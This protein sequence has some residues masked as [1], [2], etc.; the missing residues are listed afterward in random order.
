MTEE[1]ARS[2]GGR[3]LGVLGGRMEHHDTVVTT[4][5]RPLLGR[6]W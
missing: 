2:R 1:G 5:S 3:E 4:T 6:M